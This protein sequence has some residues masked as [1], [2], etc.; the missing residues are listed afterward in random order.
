MAQNDCVVEADKL[1]KSFGKHRVIETLSLSI[2]Q[3]EIILLLGPNG[4]G[5]S[6]LLRVLSGLSAPDSG[7]VQV[8]QGVRVDF[9]G[10]GLQVYPRLSVAENL[11]LFSDLLIAPKDFRLEMQEW[12]LDRFHST[13]VMSLSKGNQWRVALARIFL[14]PPGLLLLDEPTSNLDDASVD[15][16]V[17]KVQTLARESK[18]AVVIAS[19]DVA[20]LQASA[21]RIVLLDKGRV[22]SDSG[23]KGDAESI[24]WHI[25]EYRRGNR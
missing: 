23:A 6:T 4:A 10:T 24:R 12:G 22:G 16:L 19:H 14:S 15:T 17:Q 3:G 20:R 25:E 1:S 13:P 11:K 18:R 5:K 21:T 9:V 8:A 7:N 2:F